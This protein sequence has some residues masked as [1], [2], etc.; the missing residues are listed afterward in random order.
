MT[1]GSNLYGLKAEIPAAGLPVGLNLTA[2]FRI[3]QVAVLEEAVA[4]I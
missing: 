3:A 1:T 2:V 4:V